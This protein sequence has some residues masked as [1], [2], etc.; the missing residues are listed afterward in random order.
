MDLGICRFLK[1]PRRTSAPKQ[2]LEAIEILLLWE[3]RVSRSRLLD[4]FDIH[5]TLASRDIAGFRADHPEACEPEMASKSYVASW[6]LRPMLTHGRFEEYQRL[7]G[8]VGS[9]DSVSANVPF[10]HTQIDATVIRFPMFSQIHSAMRLGRCLTVQYRSMSNPE[11]HERMIRPH[12]LI[13][14]GPRWHIRAYCAKANGYRDFNLGRISAV[15][16][17]EQASLPGQEQ[18]TD[19]HNIVSI[20]LVPHRGLSAQQAMMVREEYMGGTAATVFTVRVPMAK[21]LIQSFRAAV[22]P[23]RERAPEH[24]LMVSHPENLPKGSTW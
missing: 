7:I 12:S 2:R 8:A 4:L 23:E 22:D 3:G 1:M 17:L 14:A 13:Q 16:L 9:L 6:N 10:E 5:E 20:R 15:S 11:A 19:W 24:L 18:D 21:Y